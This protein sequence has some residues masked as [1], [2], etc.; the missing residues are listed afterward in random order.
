MNEYRLEACAS[1]GAVRLALRTALTMQRERDRMDRPEWIGDTP[2]WRADFCP[3]CR[4][5]YNDYTLRL[6]HGEIP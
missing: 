1:C 4:D 6:A 2:I 5:A 3:S